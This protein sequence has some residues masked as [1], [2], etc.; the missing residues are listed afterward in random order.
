MPVSYNGRIAKKET[1]R[2]LRFHL[3]YPYMID[4]GFH[5]G[6]DL[7]CTFLNRMIKSINPRDIAKQIIK[8]VPNS[9]LITEIY[10][11]NRKFLTDVRAKRD[12]CRYDSVVGFSKRTDLQITT[13]IRGG[14]KEET[15]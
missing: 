10:S 4:T 3:V 5:R 9:R 13:S 15:V 7:S 14:G 2:R 12:M 6:K 11:L 1:S 8:S